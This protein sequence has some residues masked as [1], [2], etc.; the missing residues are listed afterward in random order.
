MVADAGRRVTFVAMTS[1]MIDYQS[2]HDE[3]P[4]RIDAEWRRLVARFGWSLVEDAAALLDEVHAV[5]RERENAAPVTG[6]QISVELQQHYNRRLYEAFLAGIHHPT[7]EAAVRQTNHASQEI[8]YAAWRQV[9]AKGYDE[10]IAEELAQR[11]VMLLVEKPHDVRSPG[12]LSAWVMWKVLGMLSA[13]HER[14]DESPL[15][16]E[17]GDAPEAQD[18]DDPLERLED[19]ALARRVI[20]ELPNLLS[21]FQVQVIRLVVLEA[22]SQQS[23]ADTL[24]VRQTRVT[25]EKSRALQKLRDYVSRQMAP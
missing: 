4:P 12:S 8:W 2:M 5:L 14:R 6:Q 19:E 25:V 15:E 9:R 7:D 21:P 13:I 11:V 20:D 17:H 1:W 24:G 10:R 16:Q 23:V 3:L 22:K 18:L